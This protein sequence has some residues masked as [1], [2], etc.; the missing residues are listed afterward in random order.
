MGMIKKTALYTLA[1]VVLMGSMSVAALA[2][3][4]GMNMY[5]PSDASLSA[6]PEKGLAQ[7]DT[8]VI[9][10]IREPVETGAVPDRS[11]S[12]SEMG[13]G[14]VGDVPTAEY[15]GQT[16]RLGIDDGS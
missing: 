9:V 8:V 7:L 5:G 3:D 10:E 2:D 4:H 15:G 13:S 12:S 11:I 6:D 1:V 14:A 16:F